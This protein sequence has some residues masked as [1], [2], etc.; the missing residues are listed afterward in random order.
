MRLLEEGHVVTAVDN[1]SRGNYGAI[2]ELKKMAC[3]PACYK[4]IN[5]DLGNPHDVAQVVR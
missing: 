1:L 2:K 3:G 4:Y 5:I